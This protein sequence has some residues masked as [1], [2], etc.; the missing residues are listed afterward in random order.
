MGEEKRFDNALGEIERR[1][2]VAQKRIKQTEMQ[3]RSLKRITNDIEGISRKII[4]MESGQ[5]AYA[6]SAAH[7][8]KNI[9]ADLERNRKRVL[10]RISSEGKLLKKAIAKR[11]EA[12][13]TDSKK[14]ADHAAKSQL[15]AENL[16]KVKIESLSQ[17]IEDIEKIRADEISRI[18]KRLEGVQGFDVLKADIEKLKEI[19]SVLLDRI[20]RLESM[21]GSRMEHI[22]EAG[23]YQTGIEAERAVSRFAE[24]LERLEAETLKLSNRA[25]GL[26]ARLF[27]AES[28]NEDEAGEIKRKIAKHEDELSAVK[29][30][31]RQSLEISQLKGAVDEL[32]NVKDRVSKLEVTKAD[33]DGLR[34]M[35]NSVHEIIKKNN[36]LLQRIMSKTVT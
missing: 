25:D 2:E 10:L 5:K 7:R 11:A 24:R 15:E 29:D 32:M 21:N 17:K 28:H 4:S 9:E 20:E 18:Y 13:E 8:I 35:R 16:L 6:N 33:E 36:D 31:G 19:N 34:A 1:L 27:A 30:S 3:S 22:R 14:K 12:I 26:M 23:S